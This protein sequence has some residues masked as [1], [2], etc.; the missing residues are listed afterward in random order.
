MSIT[1]SVSNSAVCKYSVS[2]EIRHGSGLGGSRHLG[3][4]FC[5]HFDMGSVG[6][7][8]RR[9][10]RSFFGVWTKLLLLQRK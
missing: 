7:S 2:C 5:G 3:S 9:R 10:R 4:G 1:L 8:R 6:S